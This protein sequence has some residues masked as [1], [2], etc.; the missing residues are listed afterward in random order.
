MNNDTA[1]ITAKPSEKEITATCLR[2]GDVTTRTVARSV[3]RAK[4]AQWAKKNG[5]GLDLGSWDFSEG[6]Q[7]VNGLMRYQYCVKVRAGKRH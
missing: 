7:K 6:W 3:L 5:Y 4:I 2:G 1:G